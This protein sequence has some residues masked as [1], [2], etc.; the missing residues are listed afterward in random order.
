[1]DH[2][3]KIPIK[4]K[5]TRVVNPRIVT[6][7][8]HNDL[9]DNVNTLIDEVALIATPE[10]IFTSDQINA[11]NEANAPT[12]VN[13]FATMDDI[14]IVETVFNEDEVA[15]IQNANGPTGGNYFI[16]ISEL[17]DIPVLYL[18]TKTYAA[19]ITQSGTGAPSAV[20][21]ENTIGG[22]ITWARTGA[23]VYTATS[24]GFFTVNKTVPNANPE[25]YIDPVSGNKITAVRTS[26]NIIT[27]TT[28]DDEDTPIDD[29]LT[30]RYIEIVVYR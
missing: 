2:I 22:A 18:N 16:T 29:A 19:F 14:P 17:V 8:E 4:G 20:V 11:I 26:A 10:V 7:D 28:T 12:A 24:G 27:I 5:K 13:H 15:A 23:G 21:L 30:D 1:M 9:I 3:D 6:A 25:L